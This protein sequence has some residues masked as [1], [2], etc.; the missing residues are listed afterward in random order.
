MLPEFQ[1]SSEVKTDQ[2]AV[3]NSTKTMIPSHAILVGGSVLFATFSELV[4]TM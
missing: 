2:F 3:E 4:N 1:P